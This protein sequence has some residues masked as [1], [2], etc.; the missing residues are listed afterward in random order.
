ML[1][2]GP[3]LTGDTS[4]PSDTGLGSKRLMLRPTEGKTQNLFSFTYFQRSTLLQAKT[5][6][7]WSKMF[8]I[9]TDFI[10]GVW[11]RSYID[12]NSWSFGVLQD[13]AGPDR[14]G[15]AACGGAAVIS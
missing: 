14:T 12:G 8:M 7:I 9:L 5:C 2:P 15:F 1:R 4:P 6:A 10:L 13:A 3:M 11:A